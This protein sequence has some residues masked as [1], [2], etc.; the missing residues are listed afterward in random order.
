MAMELFNQRKQN[1]TLV[2]FVSDVE[3]GTLGLGFWPA[4]IVNGVTLYEAVLMAGDVETVLS[5]AAADVAEL[6]NEAKELGTN[7]STADVIVEVSFN[8]VCDITDVDGLV[9]VTRE[10]FGST[11]SVVATSIKEV[12][13]DNS[14][15][16]IAAVD[17][18]S[19]RE[20]LG[21]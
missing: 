3:I 16:E 9:D 18:L 11:A 10:V 14:F 6:W 19:T 20:D 1:K 21:M 15:D 7:A 17:L 5:T 13:A 2:T 4:V 12:E 8:T